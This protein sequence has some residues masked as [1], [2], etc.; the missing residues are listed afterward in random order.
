M[1]RGGGWL[2]A[3]LLA[4]LLPAGVSG[5]ESPQT[6]L[7]DRGIR[8]YQT[9]D[10]E[11]AASLLRR[12]LAASAPDTLTSVERVRAL[13]YLAAT[14]FY[15]D[16]R[17]SATMVFSRLVRMAPRARPDPLIFPPE[18]TA[19]YDAVR[20]A[21]KVVAADLP[22]TIV[23]L[24]GGHY[25]IRL[26]ASSFHEI[27]VTLEQED[28]RFL[29]GLY[30]GPIGDTLQ[31]R[32]D[33]TDS[34]GVPLSTGQYVIAVTSRPTPGGEVLRVL[35]VPLEVKAGGGRDTLPWPATPPTPLPERARSGPALRA[36]AAGFLGGTA[37]LALPSVVAQDAHP[38]GARFAVAGA[39]SL[40]GL[41]G[42]FAHKPGRPLPENVVANRERR[43]AW[44]IVVDSVRRENGARRREVRL[45]I[46]SG[47]PVIIDREA[48]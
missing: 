45:T 28:G 13:T 25:P 12:A 32:W 33:G 9:L 35:R 48:P 5:Q 4:A 10:Y 16:R 38:A 2:A 22:D 23:D 27:V 14:D 8:A 19:V 30:A 31:V 44:Q 21:T 43:A 20:R 46:R 3:L 11:T 39:V 29:R 41:F 1:R 17:D 6:A 37:A 40:A 34:A 47:V 24:N 15:R 18:V 7:L 26:A 36:L 42:Y